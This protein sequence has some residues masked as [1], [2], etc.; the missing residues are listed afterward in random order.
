MKYSQGRIQG[1]ER[2]AVVLYAAGLASILGTAYGLRAL[3]GVMPE[4]SQM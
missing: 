3:S 2:Y 1:L 4:Q